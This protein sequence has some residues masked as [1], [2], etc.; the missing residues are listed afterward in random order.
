MRSYNQ[1]CPIAKAAEL[2]CER[3]TPI[4]LRDLALGASRFSELKRGA[5]LASP[6]LLTQRL[7]QLEAEGIVER[8]RAASGKSWTYHLTPAGTEFVPI[9]EALGVWGMRW[10][11]RELAD[12]EMDLGLLVWA[13]ER[14]ANPDA[15]GDRRTVVKM[16]LTD[17]PKA[18][19]YWWFVNAAGRCELCLDDPGYD[20]DL[21]LTSRLREMIEVWRGDTTLAKALGSSGIEVHGASWA[22][23]ALPRWLSRST[24]AHVRSKRSPD[25]RRPAGK[26]TET[27]DRK[28]LPAT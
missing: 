18:K 20:V 28:I 21:Y 24:L 19:R 1:F 25:G 5:P 12:N 4:I 11:R 17:Q 2:F 14:G 9:V 8:R 7:R 13:M 16:E 15:F 27:G 23:R 26:A 22:R 3:W 6:T 10:S